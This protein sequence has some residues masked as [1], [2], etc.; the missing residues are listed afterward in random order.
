M[1]QIITFGTLGAKQVLRDVGRV[2]GLNQFEMNEWS[3]LIP[4]EPG[5]SLR[6]AYSS[7]ERLRTYVKQSE[8]NL[9]LFKT[10][11][12]LEGLPRHFSIHAAGIVLC[13]T[14]LTEI[15]PLQPGN[16]GVLLTQ[17]LR[18]MWSA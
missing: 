8:R 14:D 17:L 7:S 10:A 1:A 9:L 4:R 18:T 3:R 13:D 6:Q 15:V 16:D 2:L 12:K 5:I 11:Y